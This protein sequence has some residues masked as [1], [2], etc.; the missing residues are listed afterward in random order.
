LKFTFKIVLTTQN[1]PQRIGL[2]KS[3]LNETESHASPHLRNF[4]ELSQY[5]DEL[6][7]NEGYEREAYNQ[8]LENIK[9]I[10]N[11]IWWVNFEYYGEATLSILQ[12]LG[13]VSAHGGGAAW[14]GGDPEQSRRKSEMA[15]KLGEI[16]EK[17]LAAAKDE[18]STEKL[19]RAREVLRET[20]SAF[21]ELQ[22]ALKPAS[23]KRDND[24]L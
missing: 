12:G 23:T 1:M 4:D 22:E 17:E 21:S 14:D 20:I 6:K 11:E 7:A 8:A 3:V 5:I 18:L 2:F 15:F 9:R 16:K 10:E 13:Q 19:E 24:E